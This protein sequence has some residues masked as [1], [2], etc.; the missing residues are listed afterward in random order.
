[1]SMS[2]N[3][4]EE[5]VLKTMKAG[6]ILHYDYRPANRRDGSGAKLSD[7]FRVAQ[8]N[9]ERGIK[10]DAIIADLKAL[11]A[12]LIVLQ[13]LDINCR[14]SSYAN[15][16]KE[17]A[18][19]LEAEIYFLCEFEELDSSL[20]TPDAAIGPRSQPALEP[21]TPTNSDRDT[22]KSAK[23]RHFHG[24]AILSRCVSL[25]E[26]TVIPLTSSLKWEEVGH[27]YNEPRR[28]FRSTLR[29]CVY[30]SDRTSAQM[31]PLYI[32]C[33]HFEVYCGGLERVRQLADCMADMQRITH[34]STVVNGA[35]VRRPAF[36]LAG[37]L[38]TMAHGIV[39]L[40][41]LFGTDRLRWLSFG[42]EE[43]CWLQRKV[44]GRNMQFLEAR[45]SPLSFRFLARAISRVHQ[46][47]CSNSLVWQYVY[48]FTKAEQDRMSN[49]NL[50][51][52][53]PSD[54]VTSITLDHP[55]YHG[56][57]RGKFDWILLSNLQPYPFRTARDGAKPVDLAALEK[58]GSILATSY[59]SRYLHTI[60]GSKD[61]KVHGT[62][63]GP[64]EAAT[65]SV[66]ADGYLLFN[67]N[68]T[69]SDH[70]GLV[71][72]V[73]QNNGRPQDVY[74]PHG[75]PY[76][77]NWAA[78]SFFALTRALPVAAVVLGLYC[79]YKTSR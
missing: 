22:L 63:A 61:D 6:D 5:Q 1:M 43:A 49:V 57:V 48:G 19:A 26:P 71:M 16:P 78:L 76:T 23:S 50:C 66:P 75:A 55:A 3:K 21:E 27:L 20:R 34:V 8:W 18:R 59:A 10:L 46:L 56:F 30:S 7:T 73:Q 25:R 14:R 60:D 45:L 2:D 17:I 41:R 31:A 74:P 42:E 28:G 15:V 72:T 70:R 40:S 65:K 77:A 32:Y 33:C 13:E 62:P 29:V 51:L 53:D 11:H 44:L 12:D 24:N 58:N 54:K 79:R 9:I 37:D 47:V 69:A 4:N 67:E 52:Y 38:N 64:D 35:S 68:Y 39:R 36:L